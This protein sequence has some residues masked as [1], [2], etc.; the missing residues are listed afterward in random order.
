MSAEAVLTAD[1]ALR[2]RLRW[3]CRRGMKELDLLLGRWLDEAWSTA[4]LLER[5]QFEQILE[6]PDPQIADYLWGGEEHPEPEWH[7]LLDRLSS[8]RHH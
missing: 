2:R 8:P 4:S 3:R 6:W 7:R 1:E 5:Q